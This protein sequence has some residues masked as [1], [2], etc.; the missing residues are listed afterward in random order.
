MPGDI[1][2]VNER[3]RTLSDLTTGDIVIAY[4]QPPEDRHET[5][6][7]REFIEPALLI[8]NSR[9]HNETPINARA[10]PT[11]IAGVVETVHRAL[12]KPR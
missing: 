10:I 12:R 11:R 6:V 4:V 7:M 1:V 5:A 8:T 3:P 2:A 9:E